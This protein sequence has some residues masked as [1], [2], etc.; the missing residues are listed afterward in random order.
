MEPIK[1]IMC[2]IDGTLINDNKELTDY[3]RHTLSKLRELNVI[4]GICTGRSLEAVTRLIKN[5]Q[6]EDYCDILI[7]M[8]GSHI[9][10][11]KNKQ[12]YVLASLNHEILFDV[13]KTYSHL[14]VSIGASINN[15]YHYTLKNARTDQLVK[16]NKFLECCNHFEVFENQTIFK[17]CFLGEKEELDTV[18]EFY[19]QHPDSRFKLVRSTYWCLECMPN[20]SSKATGIEFI[21]NKYHVDFKNIA[22]FGDEVNDI[23]MFKACGISVLMANGNKEVKKYTNYTTDSNN[24]DGVAKFIE[25]YIVKKL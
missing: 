12:E 6:I 18:Q 5:W 4:F 2:D 13:I 7:G 8:N 20:Q 19:N 21:A 17:I 16:Q 14:N 23:E 24:D 9:L 22:A 1:M 10:D 25:Q 15:T 11:L 3:T